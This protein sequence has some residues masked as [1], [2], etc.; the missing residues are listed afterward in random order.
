MLLERNTFIISPRCVAGLLCLLLWLGLLAPARA[1]DPGSYLD[2]RIAVAPSTRYSDYEVQPLHLSLY[3][4]FLRWGFA[5]FDVDDG[6]YGWENHWQHGQTYRVL[7]GLRLR[8]PDWLDAAGDGPL[9][10]SSL[11]LGYEHFPD[12]SHGPRLRMAL[13]G[14]Y[15]FWQGRLA[16]GIELGSE[17]GFGS[18]T[19]AALVAAVAFPWSGEEAARESPPAPSEADVPSRDWLDLRLRVYPY[20]SRWGMPINY[21][22]VGLDVS[23]TIL[24]HLVLEYTLDRSGHFGKMDDTYS[25]TAMLGGRIR[26]LDLRDGQGSGLVVDTSL[27]VGYTHYLQDMW[28]VWTAT[29]DAVCLRQEWDLLYFAGRHFG[30]GLSF[31]LGYTFPVHL[32][33]SRSDSSAMRADGGLGAA[34]VLA[35]AF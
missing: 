9:V 18:G 1:E 17:I 13:S 8:G 16:A 29:L 25:H 4:G 23:L 31:A 21:S 11:A 10:E 30:A 3:L 22:I 14:L 34:V 32:R 6:E 5:A 28:D 26:A 15:W 19:H 7:A 20:C 33:G 27:L 24:D 12:G 2:F 35:T